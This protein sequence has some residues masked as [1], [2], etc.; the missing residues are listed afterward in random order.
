MPLFPLLPP[1]V[2]EEASKMKDIRRSTD[3]Q[4]DMNERRRMG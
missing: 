2:T 3:E 4:H 1:S